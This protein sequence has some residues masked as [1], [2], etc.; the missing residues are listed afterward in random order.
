MTPATYSGSL[1]VQN[2]GFV[3]GK[4]GTDDKMGE[5]ANT[6]RSSIKV[7]Y[8]DTDNPGDPA[9]N[10]AA[11]R[12]AL[13][14]TF[15]TGSWTM[16]NEPYSTAHFGYEYPYINNFY[17]QQQTP[18][19]RITP[20]PPER[21][22]YIDN[23]ETLTARWKDI[24]PGYNGTVSLDIFP[25]DDSQGDTIMV[26]LALVRYNA[27]SD[28]R[29][30]TGKYFTSEVDGINYPYYFDTSPDSHGNP[31]NEYVVVLD[32]IDI[33]NDDMENN[34]T[35][36]RNHATGKVRPVTNIQA[37]LNYPSDG[38]FSNI[39]NTMYLN[40]SFEVCNAR[41]LYNVRYTLNA[42][43]TQVSNPTT[44]DLIEMTNYEGA[45]ITTKPAGML[46]G[47]YDGGG[48]GISNLHI[49]SQTGD[50]GMFS[51]LDSAASVR[52]LNFYNTTVAGNNGTASGIVAGTNTGSITN[53]TVHSGSVTALMNAGG[54]AGVNAGTIDGC[55]TKNGVG[56]SSLQVKTG[57]SPFT[58]N[59]GGIAGYNAGNI[60]KNAGIT[61]SAE[62]HIP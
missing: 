52:N 30:D 29:F 33:S 38:Y 58:D 60:I 51:Q 27:V 6:T 24:E 36:N 62:A 40:D 10:A 56:I 28:N 54:I 5:T 57:T 15:N 11:V 37:K 53:V 14:D 8:G 35:F 9:A 26:D 2:C 44:G 49:K 50:G 48:R 1:M 25:Q 23:G 59:V 41:H 19:E 20:Q 34:T 46:T 45:L 4:G 55:S 3:A 39:E 32:W 13:R 21:V 22:F 31:R 7:F 17:S 43:F 12:T 61:A 47:Y 42:G 18:W 16:D